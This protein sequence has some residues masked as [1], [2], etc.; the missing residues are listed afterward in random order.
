MKRI[1][2]QISDEESDDND[3]DELRDFCATANRMRRGVCQV[4]L[5]DNR[6]FLYL[7]AR[8]RHLDRNQN[9]AKLSALN[10]N[11]NVFQGPGQIHSSSSG[12]QNPHMA[13]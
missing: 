6:V 7:C 5:Q 3:G 1:D 13:K 2:K 12:Q 10:S 9:H 11:R 8:C 4:R